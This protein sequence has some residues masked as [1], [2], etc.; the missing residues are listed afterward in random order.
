MMANE[1]NENV[2]REIEFKTKRCS[3]EKWQLSSLPCTH[4]ANL[5]AS[6][7]NVSL[8]DYV[9]PYFNVDMHVSCS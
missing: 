8:V 5:I 6:I 4:V 7:Q 2:Q 3:Y 1:E 9:N